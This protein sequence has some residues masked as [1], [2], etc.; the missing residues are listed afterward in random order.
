MADLSIYTCSS[1]SFCFVYLEA[2]S[3]E[4]Y[5]VS[6]AVNLLS[7]CLV[8]Q[9]ISSNAFHLNVYFSVILIWLKQ[10]YLVSMVLVCLSANLLLSSFLHLYVLGMSLIK[11]LYLNFYTILIIFF[12]KKFVTFAQVVI[13]E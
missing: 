12:P 5:H 6:G 7:L 3:L 9:F 2:D 1:N 10:F 4:E 8:T 13:T 11:I